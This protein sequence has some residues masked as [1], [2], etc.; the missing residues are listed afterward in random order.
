MTRLFHL[1]MYCPLQETNLTEGLKALGWATLPPVKGCS[2]NLS[3][4]HTQCNLKASQEVLSTWK[5]PWLF[6]FK[7]ITCSYYCEYYYNCFLT[8]EEKTQLFH[9]IL[10]KV[11]FSLPG[12]HQTE[13]S[14]LH[15]SGDNYL[16]SKIWQVNN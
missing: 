14:S 8:N 11:I 16:K 1:I 3:L 15:A 12:H 9:F 7:R 13:K 5:P 6:T 2:Y 4:T 10:W